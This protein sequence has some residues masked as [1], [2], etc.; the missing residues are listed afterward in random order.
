MTRTAK[1]LITPPSLREGDRV[2][3]FTPSWP[4]H[5]LFPEK[6]QYGLAALR[7][8][9]F[10]VVE[11][12]VTRAG[13]SQGYRTASPRDR[14]DEFMRLVRDPGI[15]AL[16]ATMGGLNSASL[17]PYLDFDEIRAHPK[18]ICGYSDV[19]ALHLAILA[20][21]G[22][23]TFY[24]PTVVNS[25]GEWPDVLEETR[26][27]FLEAVSEPQTAP[28]SLK[29]PTR[30]SHHFRDAL[31]DAW[32]TQEREY[33]PNPG[34]RALRRGHASGQAI[35]ANLE[36]L[37]TAAGTPYFPDLTGR[38]L[39][40]E[41][42]N[43]SLGFEERAFRQLERMGAFDAIAGLVVGKPERFDQHGAPF[44]FDELVLEIVGSQRS[45]PIV[46][47]FDCGH[48]HPMLTIAEMTRVTLIVGKGFDSQVV[49]ED[50]MV[51]PR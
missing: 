30:W 25:F 4:A 35:V 23:R 9:G 20:F 34:W 27:S 19:T 36:T 26:T 21:S 38:I 33:Q 15:R 6:Y 44:T 50:A 49:V 48:T 40:V 45:F 39:I 18:V 28:R 5:L 12:E 29:P 46:T 8:L 11:G 13:I 2:G 41:D 14:A 47:N 43:G 1:P 7:R 42:W 22:V 17:I 32:R 10:D 16:I 37:L 51:A 31:T 3:V 24:G